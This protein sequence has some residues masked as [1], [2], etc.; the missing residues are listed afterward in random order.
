MDKKIIINTKNI[1]NYLTTTIRLDKNI[2]DKYDDIAYKTNH[3]RNELMV[4]ALK[5]ALDY[6]E[7]E[8]Y[9]K[10]IE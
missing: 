3:S 6:M 1:D 2:L 5:F 10:N 7:I 9:N 8:G 4:L